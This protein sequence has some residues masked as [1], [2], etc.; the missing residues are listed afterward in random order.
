MENS[1]S[2]HHR[3]AAEHAEKAALHYKEAA[4]YYEKGNPDKAIH[5]A[6][7]AVSHLDYSSEHAQQAN[8][9]CFKTM[10]NDLLDFELNN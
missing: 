1:W 6:L 7:L 10:F 9:Y 3:K 2:E 8:E 5:Q 4:E